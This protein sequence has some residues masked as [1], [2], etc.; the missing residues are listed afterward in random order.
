MNTK[1]TFLLFLIITG[2]GIFSFSRVSQSKPVTALAESI[3]TSPTQ[4]LLSQFITMGQVDVEVTPLLSADL[5]APVFELVM[6]THSVELAYDY[7]QLATLTDDQGNSYKPTK[8]TGNTSG[9]HVSGQLIFPE[10]STKPE[11]LTLTLSGVDNESADFSW[12]L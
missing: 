9:H 1:T 11:Q 12:S 7:L 4:P 6:N 3:P 10:L 8:W 5:T 2:V